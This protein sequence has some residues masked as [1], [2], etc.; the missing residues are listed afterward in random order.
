[1]CDRAPDIRIRPVF[2][3]TP[4][5]VSASQMREGSVHIGTSGWNYAH[6][7]EVFYS[8]GLSQK[9]WLAHYTK[10]FRTV[11]INNSF[12][13]LPDAKT[14]RTWREQTPESFVFSVKASRYIT[15]MKKLK[16]PDEPVANFLKR[17]TILD[18]KLGPVLF[19]L[20][21]KWTCNP[22]RLASF[23]DR[24]PDAHSFAFEFRDRSWWNDDVVHLLKK[25]KA[26][27]CI[28]ELAGTQSPKWITADF[29][30]IRLHGPGEN[31]Y[32]GLYDKQALSGWAG[33]VSEW[34]RDGR[35]VYCYFDNDQNGYAVRNARELKTM[36]EQT[37]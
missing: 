28:Y 33:A 8:A 1:M 25:N 17:V 5:S 4:G 30:Y 34:I 32:E 13:N 14:I 24:L 2:G 31:K 11:E 20:P 7:K 10:T 29:A 15:H 26:A 19:Q 9:D 16:D 6:W 22:E 12:Y 3:Y 27:F 36:L 18:R 35:R 37:G 23:L 21:P